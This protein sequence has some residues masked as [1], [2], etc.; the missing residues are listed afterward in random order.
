MRADL[1]PFCG[2]ATF[3]SMRADLSPFCGIVTFLSM[4]AAVLPNPASMAGDSDSAAAA[5][6]RYT[7]QRTR[8]FTN[9]AL[10]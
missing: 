2:I 3:L 1:S 4:R 8:G 5:A 7:P 9:G 10:K 6:A